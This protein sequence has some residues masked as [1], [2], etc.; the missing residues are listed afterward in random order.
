MRTTKTQIRLRGCARW[1][2]ISIGTFS[3]VLVHIIWVRAS[4]V[5]QW[6]HGFSIVHLTERANVKLN[7]LKQ[8]SEVNMWL[9]RENLHFSKCERRNSKSLCLATLFV[10]LIPSYTLRQVSTFGRLWPEDQVR[11]CVESLTIQKFDPYM[12]RH[13]WGLYEVCG[14]RMPRSACACAQAV[15]GHRCPLTERVETVECK[16]GQV[17]CTDA[18]D[19]LSLSISI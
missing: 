4:K 9:A 5:L 2:H 10:L 14:Q 16:N 1:A 13:R 6:T 17:K 8:R 11:V 18:Q 12:Q 15:L 7:C 3:S 19:D